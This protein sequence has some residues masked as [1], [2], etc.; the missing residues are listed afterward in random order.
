ME[1]TKESLQELVNQCIT[2][3]DVCRKLNWIPRGGNFA[4][5]KNLLTKYEIDT[6]HF[7][8]V[9]WSKGKH[10]RGYKQHKLEEILVKNSV[11]KSTNHLKKRL[12]D[13]GIKEAKCECCGFTDILELHHINGDSTDNR[14]ENLQIL[15]PNCH[16][17]TENFRG[18]NSSN[19]GRRSTPWSELIIDE[20][21][22]EQRATLRKEMKKNYVR[23]S[24]ALP[25]LKYT[26]V[27]QLCGKEFKTNDLGQKYCSAECYHNNIASDRPDIITL[28]LK[29][30]EL[31]SFV[32][33]GQYFG[34]S[35]NAVRKWCKLYKIPITYKE[36]RD[37]LNKIEIKE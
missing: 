34:V 15:C 9:R 33:V 16:A 2:Y 10:V 12:I 4:R 20:N 21:E 35:D 18:R 23:K 26:K 32:Q 8:G 36:F 7:L 25:N 13:E 3:A 29:F 1:Y 17:K 24:P 14:L 6:S 28:I 37:F 27:C 5:V 31:K 19:R 11:Y 22:A 30:K